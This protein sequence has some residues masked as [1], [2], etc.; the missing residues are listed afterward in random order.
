MREN[1]PEKLSEGQGLEPSLSRGS[2]HLL[3]VLGVFPWP[4]INRLTSE[5]SRHCFMLLHDSLIF[6]LYLVFEKLKLKKIKE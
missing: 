3:L 4:K 2:L 5:I 6:V 1:R